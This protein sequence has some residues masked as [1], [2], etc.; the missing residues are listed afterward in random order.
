MRAGNLL[1]LWVMF[2]C[3]ESKGP[4]Q[5][6]QQEDAVVSTE[7]T[8]KT[9]TGELTFLALGDSYTIGERVAEEERWPVQLVE[10]LNGEMS[11]KLWP[12]HIIARTGWTTNELQAGINNADLNPPYDLVSLLIGVNNQYRGYSVDQYKK[13]FT[14]LLEQ[15]IQFAGDN[16]EQV[17]VVSI[18]DYGVT[19]FAEAQNLDKEKIEKEIDNYND[20][21]KKIAG[22]YQIEYFD[23]TSISRKAENEPSLIAKDGLHPSGKMYKEWVELILPRAMHILDE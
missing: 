20:I 4:E 11:K 16:P 13:E 14:E 1:I 6:N 2:S 5:N 3:A 22:E 10:R 21:A 9:M 18:P 23:I 17:F 15:A 7:D 19:P 8:T 12:P